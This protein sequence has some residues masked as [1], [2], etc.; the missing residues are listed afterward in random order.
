MV[1]FQ[2]DLLLI[3]N[4]CWKYQFS[5]SLKDTPS[6][7]TYLMNYATTSAVKIFDINF[8][9]KINLTFSYIYAIHLNID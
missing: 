8:D 5:K 7:E 6:P 9:A 3:K 4:R 2:K 1:L